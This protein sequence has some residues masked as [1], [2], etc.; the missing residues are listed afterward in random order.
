MGILQ[1]FKTFALKGNV[2]DMAVG[3]IIGASFGKIVS[4]LVENVLMPPIG[5]LLAGVDF[6]KLSYVIQPAQL[7]ESGQVLN[8]AV[9]IQYGLF[10]QNII[11][12]TIVAFCVFL[13]V[14]GINSLRRPTPAGELPAELS[15]QE[16]LL[17]EIRDLLKVTATTT[18][19]TKST[20]KS[21]A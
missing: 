18:T 20:A 12:F 9:V 4:S 16:L 3:I 6:S 13:L 1:E 5:L 19:P 14:K 17:S 21:K 7:S 2:V 15:N 11:D 10:L 8:D